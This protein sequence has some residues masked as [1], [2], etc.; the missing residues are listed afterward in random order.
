[1]PLP[2]GIGDQGQRYRVEFLS[3]EDEGNIKAG[4]NGFGYSNLLESAISMAQSCVLRPN[5]IEARIIDRRHASGK[6]TKIGKT[7]KK[8]ER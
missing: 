2:P 6:S 8:A 7:F 5:W 1:M 4:W 3:E